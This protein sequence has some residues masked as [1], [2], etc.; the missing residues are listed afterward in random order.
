MYHLMILQ[1]SLEREEQ[2]GSAHSQG[3]SAPTAP[4][5]PRRERAFRGARSRLRRAGL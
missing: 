3:Q 2:A 5:G 1:P 4:V